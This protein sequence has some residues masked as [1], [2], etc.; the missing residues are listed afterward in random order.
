MK[1][2]LI[3]G[4]AVAVAVL[5]T[6]MLAHAKNTGSTDACIE[7]F[8]DGYLPA[9]HPLKI[10]K[11]DEGSSRFSMRSSVIRVSAKGKKTGKS[12][13]SATCVVDRKG[14]LVA[15]YVNHQPVRLASS[16]GT[17]ATSKGG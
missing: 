1:M 6:P 5:A 12:Y 7:A 13:G 16:A 2:N 14:E 9:G 11:R 3:K 15:M 4:A 17:K 8:V 10:V